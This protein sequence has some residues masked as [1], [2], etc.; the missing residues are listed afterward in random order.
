MDRADGRTNCRLEA[1]RRRLVTH[2]GGIGQVLAAVQARHQR[3]HV[4]RF[5]T[6][7]AGCVEDH[8]LGIV[9]LQM[10]A[11]IGKRL[12]P[13]DRDIAIRGG[14][15]FHRMRQAPGLF[16]VVIL[17][18]A[19]VADVSSHAVAFAP[20]SQNSAICGCAGFP[21][22]HETHMT[23]PGLFSR[24]NSRAVSGRTFSRRLISA[25]DFIDPQPPA[26]PV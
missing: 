14:I 24:V 11:D 26:G 1:D 21:Q 25:T 6:R 9:A 10:R 16:E 8:L 2:V 12:R 17:P 7:A 18:A 4:A 13:A 15:I 20:F 22:A 19:Q 5:Q 3:P 23:P